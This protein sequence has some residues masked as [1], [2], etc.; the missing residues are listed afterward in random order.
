MCEGIN[1]NTGETLTARK[2]TTRVEILNGE[3][4][5]V[6]NRRA[7]YDFTLSPPKCVSVAALVGNDDRIVE[8][9]KQAIDVA[10][11]EL[12]TFAAVRVRSAADPLNGKDR[13]TGNMVAAVF[14]HETSRAV[15]EG[16]APDP[17][18]HSHVLVFNAT[19]D[20]ALEH[21]TAAGRGKERH[22]R[23]LQNF[24]MLRAQ[25]YVD[26]VYYHEL[27][28][29]LHKFGYETETTKTGF[30]IKGI[31]EA[32]RER[33]SKRHDKIQE[34]TAQLI[35]NGARRNEKT[36]AAAAAHDNRVRKQPHHSAEILR[37]DWLDQMPEQER[38]ALDMTLAKGGEQGRNGRTQPDYKRAFD[39]ADR[40]HFERKSV[41]RDVELWTDAMRELRG[42]EATVSGLKDHFAS[43]AY[44][45][46]QDGRRLT[47][48]ET[49]TREQ[50]LIA[51]VQVGKGRYQPLIDDLSDLSP[52]LNERQKG[53]V[54]TLAGSRD[55]L[56]VFRGGA[57]TGKSFTLAEVNRLL[58]AEGQNVVA[59]APQN[60]QVQ[61]L[62]K[63]GLR[64]AQTLA[65]FLQ[66]NDISRG[67]VILLDE[68]GQVGGSDFLK[69]LVLAKEYDC[70]VIA[71]GD[72]RQHGAVTATDALV[73]IQ[74]Y[75]QPT[76][77]WVAATTSTIQRQQA[78]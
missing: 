21:D 57:G 25:K 76:V 1:P 53:A 2:N 70:R 68:A 60:S 55:F 23:A 66:G 43:R 8:A 49:L 41:V 15:A 63:S 50:R 17:H 32:T 52:T 33:F 64:H 20:T 14:H 37:S 59:V 71:S 13:L 67:S 29:K 28:R 24:E 3:T 34:L 36:L 61:D 78:P 39:W 12:E 11:G 65:S 75:A 58:T 19:I 4:R 6:A 10:I 31:S 72:T 48:P 40:H 46:D 26:A 44:V 16:I 27:S 9:H 54:E 42:T 30:E 51:M 5:E 18:L 35:A 7:Y 38:A 22:I 73:A 45:R 56:T 69:L 62:E 47:T 77:A 74:R